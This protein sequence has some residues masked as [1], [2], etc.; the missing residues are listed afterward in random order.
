MS[1]SGKQFAIWEDV[2]IDFFRRKREADEEN[3]LKNIIKSVETIYEKESFFNDE[4]IELVFNSQKNKKEK[5]ESSL[6]FQH[7]RAITLLKAKD[8]P[9]GLNIFKQLR[10]Y[11]KTITSFRKKYE[12][13]NWLSKNCENASSVNF[14]THVIK[15]T[16]SSINAS[17]FYDSISEQK[18]TVITTSVLKNK[19]VDGAVKGNQ[20]APIFQFLELE[21]N[22]VTLVE[23]LAL[24]EQLFDC[25]IDDEKDRAAADTWI[26]GFRGALDTGKPS[27]HVLAKQIYFPTEYNLELMERSYHILC[28]VISSSMAHTIHEKIF[29]E[30]EKS[31]QK[32]LE[33]NKYSSEISPKYINRSQ[34]GVTASNHS[35]AS[36]LNAKRGGKLHLFSNRPSIWQSQIKPPLLRKSLFSDLHN[37]TIKVEVGYL[38][39]FLIRFKKLD[40]SIKEPKRKRHLDRWVN[41]IIDEFLFYVGTIQNLPPNWSSNADAKLKKSHL[42]LL[43]PYRL[44]ETFQAKRQKED[45]QAIICIDFARWLN[46]QLRGRDKQFT[47][48]AEHDR[49]W[50]IMLEQPLREYME[51]IEQRIKQSL[52]ETV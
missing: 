52:R 22:G 13:I 46:N 25:F 31:T 4:E 49:L 9:E 19:I 35:N 29:N 7:R 30:R 27:S 39:D 5:D 24:D 3:Y 33:K 18:N 20:F 23:Q 40:L 26:N 11:K 17:S 38:R 37:S 44:D 48:Q 6:D 15:L 51:P 1:E 16:H 43:D 8:K 50:K 10:L 34:L 12:P 21:L 28:N 32:L 2:I 36:Q 47:P 42:Y 41:N 45:W 14:A